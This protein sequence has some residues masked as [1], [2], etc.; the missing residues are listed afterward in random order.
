M[1]RFVLLASISLIAAYWTITA[2]SA[3]S[4]TPV[5][6]VEGVRAIALYVCA[7]AVGATILFAALLR[8]SGERFGDLGFQ[9]TTAAPW[10]W[11]ASLRM[12]AIGL[13]LGLV[14]GAL[15]G[16]GSSPDGAGDETSVFTALAREPNGPFW[17]VVMAVVGG[18]YLEELMRAFCLTR[19]ERVFGR[20]GLVAAVAVDSV[21]FG[22]GHRYQGDA[23]VVVTAVLGLVFAGIFLWRRRVLDAMIAHG[24][25][26]LFGVLAIS[27][28]ARS[29]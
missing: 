18:G 2:L 6:T 27:V 28:A 20:G 15:V 12:I 25:W 23:A 24:A 10:S 5:E 17:L 7:V 1:Q 11:S 9:P 14:A 19:F 26:D 21:V 29:G 8:G 13:P 4:M 22:L 16:G 3:V